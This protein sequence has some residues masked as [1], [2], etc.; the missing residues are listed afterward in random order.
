MRQPK[1]GIE[2]WAAQLERANRLATYATS[3][4]QWNRAVKLGTEAVRESR[5]LARRFS[6]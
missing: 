6:F 4:S 5:K 1:Y 2:H 3:Q